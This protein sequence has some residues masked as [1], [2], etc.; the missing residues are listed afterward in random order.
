MQE[1]T[2]LSVSLANDGECAV[3][4]E[5]RFGD[6]AR[7]FTNFVYVYVGMGLGSGVTINGAAFGR[8]SGNA[9][10]FG[11][12]TVVPGGHACICGKSSAISPPTESRSSSV[13]DFEERFDARHPAI[14]TWIEAGIEP[15]RIGLNTIE[16]LFD[17]QTILLGG[18]APE[19]LID[20]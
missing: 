19:W 6:V 11:H 2:R 12:T 8:A 17:P 16:N 3:A 1:A 7:Y 18:N 13:V 15:L 20:V 14:A 10:E 5:W 9:G 4:A